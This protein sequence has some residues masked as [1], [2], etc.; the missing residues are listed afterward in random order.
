MVVMLTRR[1]ILAS[2]PCFGRPP[3][4][5][6]R[7][8]FREHLLA[9]LDRY[10]RA[11]PTENGFLQPRLDRQWRPLAEQYATVVSQ[12]RL[13]FVQSVGWRITKNPEFRANTAKAADFLLRHFRDARYGGFFRRVS[14]AG[15]VQDDTKD[16]YSHAF[17]IFG[18]AHAWRATGDDKYRRAAAEAWVEMKRNL[19]DGEGFF[20]PRTSRD[21]RRKRGPNSQNPMMHLFEA[22]LELHC[23]TRSTRVLE[24]AGE[25]AGAI[26]ARLF[27]RDR[28]FLPELYTE[29]W[30]ALPIEEG[31]RVEVGHQFEWAYLLSESAVAGLPG[32]GL[33]TGRRLLDFGMRYGYDTEA[34][35]IVSLLNYEGAVIRPGKGWW[36]QCEFLRALMRY[37]CRHDRA[38]LWP[39]FHKSLEFV[40]G[41]FLDAE[42]GGWF[43]TPAG[44][45]RNTDKGSEWFAGYHVTNLYLEALRLTG[46][47]E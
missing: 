32:R 39:A 5:I 11:V 20:K 7:Q 26:F 17:A 19:R 33:E 8:W 42:Y 25:L 40:K 1:S 4:P 15:E 13:L 38:D 22:L 14:P 30:K 34:G 9:D 24:E 2:A 12:A 43:S 23:V 28:G 47:I 16:S 36:E 29:D 44:E 45:R 10:R 35:G 18:L 31:G 41:S 46:G 21:F 27:R 6:D 37:A 3:S